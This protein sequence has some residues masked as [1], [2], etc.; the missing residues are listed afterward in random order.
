MREKP[1]VLTWELVKKNYR[2]VNI[3][4][5]PPGKNCQYLEVM[6]SHVPNEI[7]AVR[8]RRKLPLSLDVNHFIVEFAGGAK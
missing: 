5:L 3:G 7:I 8:W 6:H 1:D 2:V 4:Q